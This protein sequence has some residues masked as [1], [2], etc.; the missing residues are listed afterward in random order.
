[1]DIFTDSQS[2]KE[3]GRNHIIGFFLILSLALPAFLYSQGVKEPISEKNTQVRLIVP[4]G[5][6]IA[7]VALLDLDSITT[8]Y[9]VQISI[10]TA[11]D[12][13]AAKI[14]SGEAD[15]AVIPSNL[16]AILSNK[17]TNT[18]AIGPVIWGILYIV[19]SLDI[20]SWE[21]LKGQTV[22]TFGR[23]LTPDI[24]F[25]HLLNLNGID[26]E[27]DLTIQY[28]SSAAELA[29]AFLTGRSTVSL[30]PEP[31]LTTVLTKKPDTRILIDIQAEWTDHYGSS[32]PQAS[33]VVDREFAN[34]NREFTRLFIHA[35]ATAV[36]DARNQPEK[37][38]LAAVVLSP[39]LNSDTFAA[40]IPRMN[41]RFVPATAALTS[42]EDYFRVLESFDPASIGGKLPGEEFYYP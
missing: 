38:G 40:A 17:N 19:T 21:D 20:E 10:I 6:T 23:G 18:Q 27:Q 39:Q 15:F 28:A 7:T 22:H 11:A 41:L 42:F 35:Y 31:M 33:L 26:P 25:R 30:M 3:P 8:G 34:A 1:M 4:N 5:A 32:Y 12:L 24:T 14:I 29:P 9:D 37:A 16:A 2:Q 13:L 36:E